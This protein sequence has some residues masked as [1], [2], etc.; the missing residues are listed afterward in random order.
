MKP[1]LVVLAVLVAVVGCRDLVAPDALERANSPRRTVEGRIVGLDVPFEVATIS[2]EFRSGAEGMPSSV[3]ASAGPDGHFSFE[4]P[5]GSTPEVVVRVDWNAESRIQDWLFGPLSV[6]D[7]LVIVHDVARLEG[8]VALPPELAPEVVDG[9]SL[10]LLERLGRRSDPIT[11][12]IRGSID[13]DAEGRFDVWVPAAPTWWINV[14]L[15]EVPGM[16]GGSVEWRPLST[17]TGLVLPVP[18]ERAAVRMNSP[19]DPPPDFEVGVRSSAF[20]SEDFDT[21]L[22]AVT[23]WDREGTGE[24]WLPAFELVDTPSFEPVRVRG[25]WFHRAFDRYEIDYAVD[26]TNGEPALV[27]DAGEHV[28]RLRVVEDGEPVVNRSLDMV[29]L[30][31]GLSLRTDED[32]RTFAVVD[33]G[34]VRVGVDREERISFG[35]TSAVAWF[36]LRVPDQ[37]DAT[38]DLSIDP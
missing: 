8:Q 36:E 31:G 27:I 2:I 33:A 10:E 20:L 5:R 11:L 30:A 6:R 4:V 3:T 9:L 12:G 14:D 19:A 1:V 24:A 26:P 18:L 38:L 29:T 22:R 7:E 28:V 34:P 17:R 37:L 35:D 16:V 23:V 32:G 15:D 25:D 13:L 21:S